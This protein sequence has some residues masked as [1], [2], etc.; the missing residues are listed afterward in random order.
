[1]VFGHVYSIRTH[2][3]TD[4]YIGSTTQPLS[5][6]MVNHRTDY[7]NYLDGK[8]HYVSSYEI[9]KHGDAYI[10]LIYEGEFESKSEMQNAKVR[11]LEKQ[12]VL[13]KILLGGQYKNIMKITR[14]NF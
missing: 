14:N 7:K 4:I 8:Y 10:E 3:T 9:L 6:R 2:Q 1:M 5:K 12:N 13:I 11:K